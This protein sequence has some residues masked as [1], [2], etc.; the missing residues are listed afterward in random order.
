MGAS[1]RAADPAG[2]R[3]TKGMSMRR[4]LAGLAILGSAAVLVG[5]GKS[6]SDQPVMPSSAPVTT[7][8]SAPA[9]A[10]TPQQK[11]VVAALP[12]PYNTG[13]PAAG[14]AKFAQC[15]SC[16]AIAQ[17]A[18]N[19]TG[20][21]LYGVF[22][23]KAAQIAGFD[24]S[25]DLKAANLTLDAPTLDKWIENPKALAAQTKMTFAGLKNAQD[26]YDVIAYLAT[27]KG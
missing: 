11:A 6:G 25:D 15:R 18:P 12:A 9:F 16:H 8:S 22:G 14:E 7:E 1:L 21:N 26:R 13:D 27:Q 19:L 24:F 2:G 5:C 4:V 20:P 3:A 17:G 23:T 10:P